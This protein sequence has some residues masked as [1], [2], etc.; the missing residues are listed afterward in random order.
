MADPVSITLGVIPLVG[1]AVRA[2]SA[3]HKKFKS[4]CRYSSAVRRIRERL[5]VQKQVFLNEA[6]LFLRLVVD[7]D[8]EAQSMLRKADDAVWTSSKLENALKDCAA[9]SYSACR[10]AFTSI[11]TTIAGLQQQLDLFDDPDVTTQRGKH[12]KADRLKNGLRFAF[13]ET[14]CQELMDS[15]RLFN[16]DL[17]RL[18]EQTRE[19]A[20]PRPSCAAAR[21]YSRKQLPREFASFGTIRRAIRTLHQALMAVY[22]TSDATRLRHLARLFVDASE[23]EGKVLTTLVILCNC[24]RSLT[25]ANLVELRVQS[26]VQW[27]DSSL[28]TP[29]SSDSSNSGQGTSAPRKRRKV[30]WV[31]DFESLQDPPTP[32]SNLSFETPTEPT[33]AV[34]C[35]LRQSKDLC[36]DLYHGVR[37][38]GKSACI[39]YIDTM[40]GS[41]HSF[42][43]VEDPELCRSVPA[44]G[45]F[46]SMDEV[47][48]YPIESSLSIP[49]QLKLARSIVSAVL[50]F[51]KTPWMNEYW[52]IQDLSF[53][54]KERDLSKS[55]QTLHLGIEIIPQA[56][57]LQQ[58]MEEVEST[59]DAESES[60]SQAM[61]EAMLEYGVRN[62]TL[63]SLGVVLLQIGRWGKIAT[64]DEH[65]IKMIRRLALEPARLG[66]KYK[67]LTLRCLYCDFGFGDSLSK[68]RLQEAVYDNVVCKLSDMISGLDIEDD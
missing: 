34:S 49:D 4:F 61:R 68:P 16:S 13:N 27:I 2:Y 46:V 20:E 50:K 10:V 30:H 58:L 25:Q 21:C 47:L 60:P 12:G 51:H 52:R 31:D 63:F 37:Q 6:R 66:S 33:R 8:F 39:G 32:V 3:A 57:Q 35:D 59:S 64:H 53:V 24:Q 36:S 38:G 29:S 23:T 41:R 55:L 5:E 42:F 44:P 15:L 11:S 48:N 43:P 54:R 56:G 9:E 1:E 62:I 7:N 22:S 67:E 45:D 14:K 17:A 28:F 26:Q 65:D 19:I 18:R 40:G